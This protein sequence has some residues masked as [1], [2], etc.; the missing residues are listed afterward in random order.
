MGSFLLL[1]YSTSG[2][3]SAT[4]RVARIDVAVIVLP[5]VAAALLWRKNARVSPDRWRTSRARA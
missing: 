4:M 5:A 3:N 1:A 2:L